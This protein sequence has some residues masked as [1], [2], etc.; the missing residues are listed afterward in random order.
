MNAIGPNDPVAIMTFDSQV[1]LVQDYTTDKATL[2]NALDSLQAGGKTVLYQGAYE[3]VIKASQSPTPRRTMIILS[4]GAEYGDLSAVGRGA[5]L[6]E[7]IIRGVPV[8]SIGLGFGIDRTYLQEIARGTNARFAESPNPDELL[9]IYQNLAATLR[10]QYVITLRADVPADGAEYPFG[11]TVTTPEGMANAEA[12]ARVP[13]L[14]PLVSLPDLPAEPIGEA[15]TVTADVRA[16]DPITL[17][18]FRLDGVVAATFTEPPY[19]IVID[20][21][22]LRPGPHSLTFAAADSSGGGVGQVTGIFEVAALPSNVTIVGL[23]AE[24]LTGPQAVTLDVSGQTPAVSAAFS[25]DGGA[26]VTVEAPFVFT[27]DPAALTPG[28]HT[29]SVDVLNEGGVTTTA[30]QAFSVAALPP[31]VNIVGLES[32]QLVENPLDITIETT[33]QTPVSDITLEVNN[34]IIASVQETPAIFTLDP[35]ALVPG[36]NQLAVT[37]TLESGQSETLAVEFEVAALPPQVALTGIQAGETLEANRV[38]MVEVESQ[39][40]ITGVTY[41]IDGVQVATLAAAPYPFEL[42]VL[43][44]SPGGHILTV[45][46]TNEAGLTAS[47]NAA[48]MV[49]EAPSLTATASALPSDTPLPTDT[50]TDLPTATLTATPT[51]TLDLTAA[52]ELPLLDQQA[53]GTAESLALAQATG[54]AESLAQAQAQ[55]AQ[56]TLDA[57]ATAAAVEVEETLSPVDAASTAAVQAAVNARETT[58]ARATL[59]VLATADTRATA[60]ALATLNAGATLDFQATQQAEETLAALTAQEATSTADAA[61]RATQQAATEQAQAIES[62][63][64]AA[65]ALTATLEAEATAA[66]R[67]TLESEAAATRNAQATLNALATQNARATLDALATLEIQAAVNAQATRDAEATAN[68]RATLDA[69]ATANAQATRDAQVTA[70]AQAERDAEATA[71]AQATLDAEATLSA[72]VEAPTEEAT[73]EATEEPT[74][75]APTPEPTEVAQVVSSPTATGSVT[76][77]TPSPTLT[78]IGTLAIETVPGTAE[79]GTDILPI[80]LIIVGAVILLLVIFLLLGRRRQPGQ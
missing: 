25:V 42:D 54:T 1:R 47:A 44:L 31:L 13:I 76:D 60:N 21:Q 35:A 32:G 24:S 72:Q 20:P 34:Q 80:V 77:R 36:T 50:P 30:S 61:A 66:A 55:A 37:V 41:A 22:T 56:A 74:L 7:A 8:Y 79:A 2:L 68:A 5:A 16:D 9:S 11:L 78:P 67:V 38:V 23:G 17:A 75:V 29:L 71:N 33:G 28:D 14:V 51:A 59:D 18:Q 49:S 58:E 63:A 65:A 26:P 52:A 6:N 57:Q 73:E 53:T 19:S 39:T 12:V 62:A 3:A 15:V 27:I 10:S 40:P 70:N 43:A 46:A 48:F 4:D 45:T 69:Q 64:L